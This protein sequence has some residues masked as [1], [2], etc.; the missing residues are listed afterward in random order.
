MM[1]DSL[2]KKYDGFPGG[3]FDKG[4]VHWL[5]RDGLGS[6]GMTVDDSGKVE[7]HVQYYPYGEPH[8]EPQGQ[9]YLYGGKERRR[10]GGLNDYDFH[11]RFLNPAAAL[12]HAPD[13]HASRYPWLSPY[14]FCASNP[15]RYSDPTGMDIFVFDKNGN[16]MRRIV[17][18]VDRVRIM[19]S[20]GSYVDSEP[21]DKGSIENVYRVTSFNGHYTYIHL[22][23]DSNGDKIYRFFADNIGMEYSMYKCGISG[24][25]GLNIIGT[26]HQKDTDLSGI[27]IFVR[28]LAH[29]YHIREHIHNHPSTLLWPS[30]GDINFVKI[31]KRFSSNPD[32]VFK[33]YSANKWLQL[34]NE[35]EYDEH[36]PLIESHEFLDYWGDDKFVRENE[37][38]IW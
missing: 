26:S 2:H 37:A 15:V 13:P 9:P 38:E 32:V 6:V 5:L 25:N 12:W 10:F 4:G 7:Q 24:N 16:Y 19:D 34:G 14:A 36:T 35:I 30:E 31:I 20:Y 18:D 28:M 21:M 29:G 17:D 8:R 1:Q 27:L 23:G 33:L 11:A 22:R 3:Y